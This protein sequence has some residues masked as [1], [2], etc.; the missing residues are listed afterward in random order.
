MFIRKK[1][2]IL[3]QQLAHQEIQ[4]SRL[5]TTGNL[6][7]QKEEE[8]EDQRGKVNVIISLTETGSGV[9]GILSADF[10]ESQ[11]QAGACLRLTQLSSYFTVALS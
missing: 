2:K 9:L 5:E 1:Q 4:D 8:S 11:I 10:T 3:G 6:Q 7:L